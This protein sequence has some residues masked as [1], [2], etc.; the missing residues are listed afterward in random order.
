[1]SKQPPKVF[2]SYSHDNFEH[3]QWVINLANRLVHSGVDV[4]LDVWSLGA[5]DDLPHFMETQLA[6]S[7]RI[8]MVCTENYVTKANS[9][10]GGVGYEKMIV[11]STL[12]G[13]IDS[14]KVIPIIRQQGTRQTPTFLSSKLYIDFS[15]DNEFETVIDDLLRSI[16]G[17][18]LYKK[19]EIGTNPY[20][21]TAPA[22]PQQ[23]RDLKR[24]ILNHIV[25]Y[26]EGGNSAILQEYVYRD[27][28]L[29]KIVFE[30]H[31]HELISDGFVR[32]NIYRKIELLNKGKV[33]AVQQGWVK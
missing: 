24:D 15:N 20:V 27:L 16:H 6:S 9:G 13:R 30:V 4:A 14:N 25:K 17:E 18:P 11:T 32:L 19:P 28:K 1:M 2:I 7:D 8:I 33:F 22:A 31:L 10:S 23:T 26:Y 29:S 21:T 5:G 12:L 3:K